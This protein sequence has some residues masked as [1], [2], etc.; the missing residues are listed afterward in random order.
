MAS[1][2]ITIDAV[3]A[4][5]KLNPKYLQVLWQTLT[6]ERPSFPL[7]EVRARWRQ[8]SPKDVEAVASVI[9]TWQTLLWKFNKIG[10]YMN[11]VWQDASNPA[12]VESQTIRFK[13]P[14][15]AGK[16]EVVLYLAAHDLNGRA[17]ARVVWTRPRFEGGKLPPLL[18][19]DVPE[20]GNSGL[21]K[22][23]FGRDAGGKPVEEAS[24]TAAAPSV[25]EVHLAAALFQDRE[26]MVE[27]AL[28]PDSA[29]RLVQFEVRADSPDLARPLAGAPCVGGA[30]RRGDAERLEAGFDD[31][32]CCFPLYVSYAKIV[33]DDEIINLRLF[34]RED[35]PLARLFLDDGQKRELDQLWRNLGYVSQEQYQ[36][37][38][39]NY[40]SFLRLRLAGR[41]GGTEE[42]FERGRASRFASGPRTSR[43]C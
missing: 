31:F 1:G 4:R 17:G 25:V 28:D 35:E 5:E 39:K 24:L 34:F 18:L 3:A 13:P 22:A 23:R 12:F 29:I 9:R 14:L 11:P 40:Q 42:L 21:D 41:Q 27:G 43:R 6:D 36:V 19:R 26:F 7:D 20:L 37:E 16:K 8:A 30:D 15:P 33:P 10:S 2:K 32:R 38:D